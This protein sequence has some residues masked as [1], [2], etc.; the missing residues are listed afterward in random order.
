MADLI[1]ITEFARRQGVSRQAVHKWLRR[2]PSV[3]PLRIGGV[4]LLTARDCAALLGRQRG[5]V[6]RPKKVVDTAE[7][8]M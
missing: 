5:K 8:R 2:V 6:G 4:A 3:H 1:T 7:P